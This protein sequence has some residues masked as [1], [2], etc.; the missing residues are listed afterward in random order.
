M[1]KPAIPLPPCRVTIA[2]LAMGVF[3]AFCI[4]YTVADLLH[5][6]LTKF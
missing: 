5:I 2:L 4:I 1:S 3:T 6:I